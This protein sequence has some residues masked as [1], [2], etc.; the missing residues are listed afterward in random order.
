VQGNGTLLEATYLAKC[1]VTRGSVVVA[2]FE[3][4]DPWSDAES[5]LSPTISE[6]RL[7]PHIRLPLRIWL[8]GQLGD[9]LQSLCTNLN[10]P[11]TG[12]Y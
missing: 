9:R 8:R 10:Q 7:P 6:A 4:F 11:D 2:L 1:N 12:Q 3:A 5:K